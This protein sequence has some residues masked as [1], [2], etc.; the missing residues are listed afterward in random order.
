MEPILA[1]AA[2]LWQG[3]LSALIAGAIL[4]VPLWR[5][6]ERAGVT[7]ALAFLI[8]IPFIGGIAVLVLLVLS[9]WPDERE[10]ERRFHHPT[11]HA[12]R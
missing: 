2:L 8:F 9:P 6:F 4:V 3:I 5:L 1:E 7:P 11:R 12:R 10:D